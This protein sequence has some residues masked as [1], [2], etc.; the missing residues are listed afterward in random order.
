MLPA[1]IRNT[2]S[3]QCFWMSWTLKCC[4]MGKK[5]KIAWLNMIISSLRKSHTVNGHMHMY[6]KWIILYHWN[7]WFSLCLCA[8]IVCVVCPEG[9]TCHRSVIGCDFWLTVFNVFLISREKREIWWCVGVH[10]TLE[11]FMSGSWR[12]VC[13]ICVSVH[14]VRLSLPNLCAWLTCA[15]IGWWNISMLTK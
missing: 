14:Y 10:E 5:R 2:P 1:V 6:L 15:L 4:L 9:L 13:I 7:Q 8:F 11:A 12:C 3:P